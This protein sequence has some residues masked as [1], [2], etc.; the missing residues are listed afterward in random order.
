MKLIFYWFLF[1]LLPLLTTFQALSQ[2]KP[3]HFKR[4]NSDNGLLENNVNCIFQD[5][6][7]FIWIGTNGGLNRYDGNEFRVYQNDEKD[8]HS[9]RNDM[10]T[11]MA[12][13]KS[14]NIWIATSGGGLNVFDPDKGTFDAYVSES[15]NE[16][17]VSGNYIN[18]ITFDKDGQLWLATTLG[19][20]VFDVTKR[21][22]VRRYKSDP[23][24][25]NSLGDNQINTVFC[26]RDN[27]IWVG[28]GSGLSVFNRKSG[29]FRR[30]ATGKTSGSLSGGDVRC[31]YQDSKNRIWLGTYGSGLNLYQPKDSTFRHFRHHPDEPGSVSHDHIASINEIEDDIWVGTENGGLSVLDTETWTF[32][33]QIHDETD[34]SSIAGNS[35]DYIYKD[36]QG[37]LW[38]GVYNGGINI[39]NSNTSFG[40]FRHNSS[41]VSLS[42]NVVLSFYE[43]PDRNM[44][45]GTDGGGLNFFDRKTQKFTAYRRQKSGNSI[46]GDFVLAIATD[47]DQKLWIGTWGDGVNVLDRKTGKFTVFRHSDANPASLGTDNVY[48]IAITRDKRVWMSTYGQGLDAFD[49]A[50]GVFKHYVND[51][52]NAGSLSD[53]TVNCL[54]TDRAGNLWLGTGAG[55]LNRYDLATDKFI[56][57]ALYGGKPVYNSSINSLIEDR[58]GMLWLCTLRGIVR[59]DPKTG[60]SRKY[61]TEDGL[62][63]NVTQ[64]VVEDD[65]GMLWI[66]TMDGLSMLDPKTEKFQNYSVEYGLQA[67]E[68]KQKSG[69]KD[70]AGKLYFGGVNGFNVFD[71]RQVQPDSR[72]YPIVLTSFRVFNRDIRDLKN[73]DQK[74]FLRKEISDVH[75]VTLSHDQSFISIDYAALDYT[76]ARKNYAYFLEG[77]DKEWN[78]VGDENTAVYTNLPPGSYVFKVKAQNVS[79]EW[80]AAA[81]DLT[82]VITP[83]FWQTWWFVML[84]SVVLGYAIYRFYRYR[85]NAIIRQK[86][87]LEKLVEERTATV[88]KQAEELAA[89]SDHLYALNE[90]L[91]SQSEELRV[92]AEELLE[93]HEQ[94]QLARE[95]A[96]RANQAKSIFLATMSHEIRTPMNGVIG[97]TELLAETEL[98]EEQQEYTRTIANCGESLVNVIN[99]ILDFSKIES[100]KI[101]LE[102][103]EYDLRLTIEE[104]MEIFALQ[105]AKKNIDLLY[106]IDPRLPEYLVGDSMRL[107]QILTNL[108]NN[109]LK[110]TSKGEVYLEVYPYSEPVRGEIGVG[111]RVKD[112]GIGI[113][114]DNLSNLFK[115][116][117]QVD[118]SVNRKYGGTG[119]GL[120][121]CER[122][123]RLMNGDIGVESTYGH[124]SLFYFHI[125]T[126]FTDRKTE[127]PIGPVA[128]RELGGKVVLVT[129]D[130]DTNLRILKGY[131]NQ[132]KLMP[133][134]AAS[135]GEAR[136]ILRNDKRI[137]LVIVDMDMP[138]EDGLSLAR[139][140]REEG[141]PYPIILLSAAGEG[142]KTKHTGLLSD[143]ITKPVKKSMLLRSI[144]AAL[145]SEAPVQA[146]AG[147][148]SK[149]LQENFSSRYPLEILV[150]EDNVVNQKFIDYVLK[151]LGYSITIAENGNDVLQKL[152]ASS[153]D[154]ILMDVQMPEMDG[155]EATRNIR[156]RYV[157]S[158]Y[159]VAL[160]ANAMNEDRQLCLNIGMDDYMAKPMKLEAI[161][162][163]LVKAFQRIHHLEPDI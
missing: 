95:E 151:K 53:N 115:A 132:W 45:I 71:P 128:F 77:F 134:M 137:E 56:T 67:K 159:I 37:N 76:S 29:R 48:A 123:I 49:P 117:S 79:G 58:Q 136:E 30:F 64:A 43:D 113:R 142:V 2:S 125:I 98:T 102:E 81:A 106:D 124:G 26:D 13:D 105:A 6:K 138:E 8:K 40:H 93:Q 59:F 148:E 118:S 80:I 25:V 103:L 126:K 70:R 155:L 20:D 61:T 22:V 163:V 87:E 68:F 91:Q 112:T 139:S 51:P 156:E 9:L 97:M 60:R 153:Y 36:M 109:A 74:P 24:D 62:V 111:F 147:Q 18:R 88:Q 3:I 92:Q 57:Y 150:A 38:L 161:K 35:V 133:V 47:D 100:G 145:K 131:L 83:P 101:D 89:Q 17:S 135:A 16:K 110:F 143:I 84:V 11:S 154:V 120:V 107:K 4:I 33:T 114:E 152:T 50:T 104:L 54:L 63:N 130:N 94:E 140:I 108:I 27:N 119:L 78:F 90:E 21:Q 41:P 52:Q 141:M 28:T 69:F 34:P 65:R 31:I 66:S 96:E 85:V 39:Y 86:A 158:P 73:G 15:G 75:A 129:D 44:W 7:G 157:A 10:V 5:K 42:N 99:D 122:L 121:I 32:S 72:R 55:Q 19:L 23:N 1:A 160:T 116:F 149:T 46:S 82:I 162:E 146:E 144:Y 127:K 14:G 12:E